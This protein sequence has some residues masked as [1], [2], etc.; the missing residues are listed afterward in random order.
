MRYASNVSH[1]HTAHTKQHQR[2]KFPLQLNRKQM[3]FNAP[4]GVL[5]REVYQFLRLHVSIA[6]MH[7]CLCVLPDHQEAGRELLGIPT[8]P[9]YHALDCTEDLFSTQKRFLLTIC[10]RR[11]EKK[12]LA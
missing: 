12:D 10:H 8:N 5:Q 2:A 4:V 9:G 7:V 11:Q 1:I 3:T 6:S